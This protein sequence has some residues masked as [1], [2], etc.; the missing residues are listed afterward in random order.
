MNPD[1]VL[2][3]MRRINALVHEVRHHKIM[4][5]R[6]LKEHAS[7]DEVTLRSKDGRPLEKSEVYSLY[8]IEYQSI[9]TTL[10]ALRDS[11]LQRLLAKVDGEVFRFDQ[12]D[13]YVASID[14]IIK[15][16]GFELFPEEIKVIEP[17]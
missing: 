4:S 5:E 15:E 11:L 3:D 2:D 1:P 8:V 16:L 6:A 7:D 10:S 17:L 9:F 13:G 14:K 12:F